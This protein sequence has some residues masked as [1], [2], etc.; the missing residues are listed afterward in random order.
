MYV[1]NAFTNTSQ[2][3]AHFLNPSKVLPICDSH[4]TFSQQLSSVLRFPLTYGTDGDL[5]CTTAE[6]LETA[7]AGDVN[8]IKDT[9]WE[10]LQAWGDSMSRNRS[11]PLKPNENRIFMAIQHALK[12]KLTADFCNALNRQEWRDRVTLK[13]SDQGGMGTAVFIGDQ[14]FAKLTSSGELDENVQR[15]LTL[16]GIRTPRTAYVPANMWPK[17]GKNWFNEKFPDAVKKLIEQCKTEGYGVAQNGATKCI[18]PSY[19][20]EDYVKAGE[21][22]TKT[23]ELVMEQI[24]SMN[25]NELRHSPTL[26]TQ[27]TQDDIKHIAMEM[28]KCMIADICLGIDDRFFCHTSLGSVLDINQGSIMLEIRDGKLIRDDAGQVKVWF[29]DNDATWGAGFD[30]DQR[31]APKNQ[32]PYFRVNMLATELSRQVES[33]FQVQSDGKAV[34]YST[35]LVFQQQIE[36]ALRQQIELVCESGIDKLQMSRHLLEQSTIDELAKIALKELNAYNSSFTSG[37]NANQNCLHSSI[38]TINRLLGIDNASVFKKLVECAPPL[39]PE[40]STFVVDSLEYAINNLTANEGD[41][42]IMQECVEQARIQIA[43]Q[44]KEPSD[45]QNRQGQDDCN[46]LF[47][48]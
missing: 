16:L 5:S 7:L 12:D 13:C 38:A 20:S 44:T 42:R 32:L 30:S 29:V 21:D 26:A 25:L 3:N 34:N 1:N 31:G 48:D 11:V 28:A 22:Y 35:D 15:L 39:R 2:L 9:E 4:G 24:P 36:T 27:L 6:N 45:I 37:S 10:V 43:T 33:L 8:S 18:P 46:S 19:R 23:H 40:Q 47:G 41:R 17:D 14:F